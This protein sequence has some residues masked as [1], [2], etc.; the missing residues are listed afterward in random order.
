M[1]LCSLS[2][3]M[4]QEAGGVESMMDMPEHLPGAHVWR[5]SSRMVMISQSDM[6]EARLWCR[7]PG[8]SSVCFFSSGVKYLQKSSNIQNISIKFV[9][10]TEVDVCSQPFGLQV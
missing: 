4:W 2:R 8:T 10:V 5:N 7:L 9:L 1:V 3:L 6:R